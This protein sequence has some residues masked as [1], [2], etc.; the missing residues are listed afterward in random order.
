MTY[1]LSIFECRV[2]RRNITK[3][4]HQYNVA[5]CR[6]WV[7]NSAPWVGSTSQCPNVKR[8]S[9]NSRLLVLLVLRQTVTLFLMAWPRNGWNPY[10]HDNSGYECWHHFSF[11]YTSNTDIKLNLYNLFRSVNLLQ[12]C[13]VGSHVCFWRQVPNHVTIVLKPNTTVRLK[14]HC[15]VLVNIVIAVNF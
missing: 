7:Q 10:S 4:T 3:A 15:C 1:D 8:R 2:K 13:Y 14:I 11:I 12:L 5:L 6:V 9:I